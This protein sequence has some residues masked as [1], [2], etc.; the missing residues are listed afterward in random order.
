M[1]T[2][3]LCCSDLALLD[4]LKS[5]PKAGATTAGYTFASWTFQRRGNVGGCDDITV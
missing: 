5:G 2:P 3:F 4:K 1:F